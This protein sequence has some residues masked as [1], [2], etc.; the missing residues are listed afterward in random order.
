MEYNAPLILT[1]LNIPRLSDDLV[2]RPHLYE[3][4]NRGLNRKLT[5]ISAPAGYG[6]TT[7]AAT[8][9]QDS[10]YP[11]AW[12]SLDEDDSDLIVFIT[13]IV[14]A[15]QTIFPGACPQTQSLRKAPRLP[16]LD[17]I[18]TT[19]INEIAELPV[20]F[21]T[22]SGPSFV[23]VLDDFHA[24]HNDLINQLLTKLINNLPLQLHLV[25][26]TRTDPHLPL[27]RLRVHRQM[28]EIRTPDLCFSQEE[29]NTY[30][31]Q[32]LGE[33][34]SSEIAALLEEKTEGWV[35]GLRLAAFSMLSIDDSA[36]FIKNFKGVHYNV[37]DF[38]VDEVLASQPQAVND[39]LLQ[40]SLLRHFCVPLCEAVT[41]NNFNES[42]EILAEIERQNL[43]LIPLDFER[44]WYRYHHLFQDLLRS[45]LRDQFNK[46]ELAT[47]HS[48]AS[49]WLAGN[50]F[51]EEALRHALA[52]GAAPEAAQLVEQNRHNA[53]N[54]ED[55][56]TLERWLDMLPEETI[57]R[58]PALLLA[59][60]WVL[61]IRTQLR[62]IPHLLQE[63]E[64]RLSAGDATY[65]ESE[66]Q[67]LH[68]EIDALW[69]IVLQWN[70]KSQQALEHAQRAV[71]WIPDAHSFAR[72]MAITFLALAYQS[73]GQAKSGLSALS[74]A[75]TAAD[76]QHDTLIA[77]MLYAQTYVHLLEGNLYQAA[78]SID[79]LQNMLS[80]SELPIANV[81]VHWLSGH[82][83]YEWN[84][85]DAASQ[86]LN[87]VLN[88]RY[89]GGYIMA[90]DSLLNLALTYHSLGM[91]EKADETL[92][93]LRG[94]A[95]ESGNFGRLHEIDSFEARLSILRGDLLPAA[96]WA[97]TV[98]LDKPKTTFFFLEF[99]WATKARVLIA[100][101]TE[102][103]LRE[104]IQ[105]LEELIAY[106]E[107]LH[108]TYRQIG[109]L[110]LMA[111]AFE[112]QG[113]RDDALAV[114]KRSVRL[115]QPGGFIRT[116]VDLGPDMTSLLYQ[117]AERGVEP[118]YLGQVLVAFNGPAAD[119]RRKTKVSVSTSLMVE[120][121]TRRELEI[122]KLLNT[123]LSN[124]EI[125]QALVI[126]PLTV[127]R[128]ASN[129]YFKLGVSGRV[130][131]IAQAKALGILPLD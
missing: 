105:L 103:S 29:V 24:I 36:E 51:I 121:L 50:G 54:R 97:E 99:P 37:M 84:N 104:A 126:S 108:I 110:A 86:H 65:A 70:D 88:L 96:H 128:H 123:G 74:E 30:L 34:Q 62:G 129:I 124:Q 13:Y 98:H 95:Q 39:F 114:L 27:S 89:A 21:S 131:A 18:S 57:Q 5:L 82:I 41:D 3:R 120:P 67:G 7:L 69:S 127:K 31:E 109:L 71:K 73:T 17:Y 23:L 85:L 56:I 47:L 60:A 32:A 20:D 81:I 116:Y 63:A 91:Q 12:L 83:R 49:A 75:L 102:A 44:S 87:S 118:E 78:R 92:D 52:A 38:L 64:A 77:R 40:T 42:Q 16:P 48:K 1:K 72:S 125:A 25:I 26:C 130:K 6:K 111:L 90:H 122:L 59:R 15:I 43:F 14:A 58:R 94:F 2:E 101:G 61:D 46:E 8:W 115:A 68:G 33:K 10:P 100:Q 28:T 55:W 106:A 76:G 53:L 4:L 22:S 80:A 11:V 119:D 35:A 66:L 93:A 9:L 79:Q 112:K 19:L 117:L 113:R 107:S 45:R